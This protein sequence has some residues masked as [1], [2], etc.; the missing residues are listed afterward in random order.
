MGSRQTP[1]LQTVLASLMSH[2]S[3]FLDWGTES[4]LRTVFEAVRIISVLSLF[5]CSYLSSKLL[6]G[7]PKWFWKSIVDYQTL[8]ICID[9]FLSDF[10]DTNFM[11]I[12]W[13]VPK[14]WFCKYLIF[15]PN[16]P[17]KC[18]LEK[19]SDLRS[20][21]EAILHITCLIFRT[22]ILHSTNNRPNFFV[23]LH[24]EYS[25]RYFTSNLLNS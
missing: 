16:W 10:S 23:D 19:S 25:S 20:H 17:T 14:L 13:V 24:F 4:E 21:L 18:K 2:P 11:L 5:N 6:L 22:L 9:L 15:C 12:T 3:R 8:Y 7:S 1:R